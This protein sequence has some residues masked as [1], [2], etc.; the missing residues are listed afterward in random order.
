MVVAERAFDILGH[1]REVVAD[2]VETRVADESRF[3]NPPPE[4][5][6]EP[7][8]LRIGQPL[9]VGCGREESTQAFEHGLYRTSFQS[10]F[11]RWHVERLNVSTLPPMRSI[12]FL[13]GR[14]K[15]ATF[16][17]S[18]HPE[19]R[20]ENS[21]PPGENQNQNHHRDTEG[22]EEDTEKSQTFALEFR[23]A[24]LESIS[25]RSSRHREKITL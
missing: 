4:P 2:E 10:T 3:Q 25:S 12:R 7:L 15:R 1:N 8:D 6:V 13:G 17:R 9:D 22:T 5:R 23:R 21:S 14:V 16:Q 20:E 24:I 19:F 11:A 18:A